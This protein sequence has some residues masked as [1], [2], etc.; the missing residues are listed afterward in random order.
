MDIITTLEIVVKVIGASLV[1]LGG[2]FGLMMTKQAISII[3]KEEPKNLSFEK[4]MDIRVAYIMNMVTA[5][6]FYIMSLAG[7]IMI[8]VS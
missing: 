2:I 7:L 1:I 3:A 8:C 4:A 5:I 6:F